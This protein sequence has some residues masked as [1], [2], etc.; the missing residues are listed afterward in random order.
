MI[1]TIP[2]ITDRYTFSAVYKIVNPEGKIYIGKT[3]NLYARFWSYKKIRGLNKAMTTSLERFGVENHTVVILEKGIIEQDLSRLEVFHIEE[4]K[5]YLEDIGLNVRRP[6]YNNTTGEV[7]LTAKAAEGFM[8]K[9]I[10]FPDEFKEPL[11]EL[12]DK[13][14]I[15]QNSLIVQAIERELKES[16]YLSKHN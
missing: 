10:T 2:T 12:A 6:I 14:H 16:G 7:T 9:S 1:L 5:S 13:K 4:H 11:A 3:K 15:S 8:N